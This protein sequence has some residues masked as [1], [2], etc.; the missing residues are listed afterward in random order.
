MFRRSQGLAFTSFL[1]VC[2]ACSP[3]TQET[4]P[5][6]HRNLQAFL[7]GQLPPE[8]LRITY[9]DLHGLYG[10]LELVVSGTGEVSQETKRRSAPAAA[11]L[12]DEQV[13]ELAK[14]LIN[15]RAW[16]QE[17]P[18]TPALP[19]ESRVVLRIVAGETESRIWERMREMESND[20]VIRVRR[21]MQEFAWGD[22]HVD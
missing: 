14:L 1:L 17:T 6:V 20:R 19:D 7:D 16:E 12:T 8:Q 9:S 2:S 3:Q 4:R 21:K 11:R 22:Q 18:D 5:T 15:L 10:G 13:R